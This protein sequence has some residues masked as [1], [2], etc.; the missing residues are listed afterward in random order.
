[1]IAPEKSELLRP[2]VV[3]RP[4]G[5]A[6]MKPVTT[7]TMPSASSGSKTSRPRCLVCSRC[8][9]ASRKVSQVSTNSE[10]ETG[11]AGTPERSSAAA[12]SRALIRWPNDVSLS[13]TSAAAGRLTNPLAPGCRRYAIPARGDFVEQIAAQG[14]ELASDTVMFVRVKR[15]VTQHIEMQAQKRF[16]LQTRPLVLAFIQRLR[17]S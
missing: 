6:P 12:N 16:H 2:S 8:G 7:G 14:V 15:Q 3:M 11:T 17:D 9:L 13:N 1:M 10:E 4:S 5:V